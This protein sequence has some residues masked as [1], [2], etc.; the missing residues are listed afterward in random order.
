M[1]NFHLQKSLEVFDKNSVNKILSKKDK[2]I[3]KEI[4]A[5]PLMPIMVKQVH[6][7]VLRPG[8]M[9]FEFLSFYN[10]FLL[11]KAASVPLVTRAI[12]VLEFSRGGIQ[13]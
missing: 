1:F 3:K 8:F 2:E 6:G 9:L 5:S 4:K 10:F 12:S 7:Y 13:N 11:D